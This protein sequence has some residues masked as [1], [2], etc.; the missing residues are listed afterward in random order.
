MSPD[1]Q[2]PARLTGRARVRRWTAA[3][4]GLAVLAAA[5]L[6]APWIVERVVAA[7]LATLGFPGARLD[8]RHVG[9]FETRIEGLHLD[10]LAAARVTVRYTP[11]AALSGDLYA[12][13]L[14]GVTIR[15]GARE[16]AVSL[17]RAEEALRTASGLRIAHIEFGE[18]AAVIRAPGGDWNA[19]LR[20]ALVQTGSGAL[21]GAV[22]VVATSVAGAF[23]G[24]VRLAPDGDGRTA[25][26]FAL[27]EAVLRLPGLTLEGV[28]GEI[29]AGRSGGAVPR[30]ELDLQGGGRSPGGAGL[31]RARLRLEA[32][33]AQ[34]TA[35]LA[36][37]DLEGRRFTVEGAADIVREADALALR[38][39]RPGSVAFL[40][41]PVRGAQPLALDA[42][43]EPDPVPVLRVVE[44]ADGIRLVHALRLALRPAAVASPAG[45][46][47]LDA[48]TLA[49]DGT[50]APAGARGRAEFRT[51]ALV[52]A[53][54]GVRAEQVR[55]DLHWEEGP[56]RFEL[57]AD[58]LR[59]TADPP[60]FGPLPLRLAGDGPAGA[61]RFRGTLGG[62]GDP[63]TVEIEGEASGPAAG[64]LAYRL[65]AV[66][67]APPGAL[68]A[69]SP[70]IARVAT[71]PAGR[72]AARGDLAWTA[73]GIEG[74][75]RV[76]LRDYAA[77]FPFGRVERVNGVVVLDGLAPLSTAGPQTLSVGL[78]D[79][80]LPLTDGMVSFR[81]DSGRPELTAARFEMAGGLVTLG[82]A[83]L[84]P[85]F[86]GAMLQLE[87][88]GLDLG[89]V[90]GAGGGR[91]SGRLPVEIGPG[92]VA[93]RDARLANT[94]A[95]RDPAAP[96]FRRDG[97]GEDAGPRDLRFS[98]ERPAG[99]RP[100]ARVTAD[101]NPFA[102]PG[103][104]GEHIDRWV[105]PR[106]DRH[107]VPAATQEAMRDFTEP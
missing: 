78:V 57:A 13:L 90:A 24:E 60:W 14:D 89:Q 56:L 106:L 50:I 2:R 96:A 87:A 3:A 31:E 6:A 65:P 100:S 93:I 19:T 5:W 43:I 84:S 85:A 91:Y 107:R 8:V 4:A 10:T 16:T 32:D 82:R 37:I 61:V 98:V 73:A 74:R 20:G 99:G 53:A 101:G 28:S 52:A 77:T 54:G 92:G 88:A 70:A 86:D 75:C 63:G 97:G 34:V 17:A 83:T 25:L 41:R 36:G 80:G 23:G 35:S 62:D 81:L 27:R 18:A 104:L 102:L 46:I 64:R 12:V 103:D 68:A 51:P 7:R 71:R 67:L 29:A 21:Q 22:S 30:L 69:L 48:G 49:L 39:S 33:G 95:A 11:L 76:L 79:V 47:R 15:G 9:P 45:P 42:R 26:R 58:R 94:A 38:L 44:A 105:R 72:V 40:D 55:L 59:S 66:D 1:A